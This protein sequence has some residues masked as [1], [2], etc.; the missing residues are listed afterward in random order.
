MPRMALRTVVTSLVASALIAVLAPIPSASAAS[1]DLDPSFSRNGTLFSDRLAEAYEMVV[2][3]DGRFLV[4]GSAN[5]GN[6]PYNHSVALLARYEDSGALD[7]TFGSGGFVRQDMKPTACSSDFTPQGA[8]YDVTIEPDGRIVASGFGAYCAGGGVAWLVSRFLPSGALD[9]SFGGGGH[10]RRQARRQ[11]RDL[12]QD[13]PR[14]A[15]V[16]RAEVVTVTHVADREAGLADPLQPAEVILGE[17][18]DGGHVRDGLRGSGHAVFPSGGRCACVAQA[19]SARW[20]SARA[21]DRR[22]R[23]SSA[24]AAAARCRSCS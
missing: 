20:T 11:R 4:A 15:E 16:D 21:E 22:R 2:Q 12:E 19:A 17:V 9:A 24:R 1:G 8:Y 14:L 3:P 13:P 6:F 10:V 23:R 7:T 18:A 5:N